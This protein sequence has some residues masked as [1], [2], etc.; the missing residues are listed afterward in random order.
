MWAGLLL[1]SC[2]L[3]F[4]YVQPFFIV[5]L[6]LCMFTN[7]LSPWMFYKTKYY[8]KEKELIKKLNIEEEENQNES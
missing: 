2:M 1:A 8:M 7:Y 5:V 4:G 3:L 6:A